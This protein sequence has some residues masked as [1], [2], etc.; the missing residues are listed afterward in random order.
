[1]FNLLSKLKS[2]DYELLSLVEII[3]RRS[4]SLFPLKIQGERLNKSER[5]INREPIQGHKKYL[6]L[7]HQ[8]QAVAME[9][10]T[11]DATAD[12]AL[13]LLENQKVSNLQHFIVGKGFHQPTIVTTETQTQHL[14]VCKRTLG[15]TNAII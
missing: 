4:P 2:W 11:P 12:T 5:V 15:I 9:I 8:R 1:M 3:H 6:Q 7:L 10:G 14:S 13:Q